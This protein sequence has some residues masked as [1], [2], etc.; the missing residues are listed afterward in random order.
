VK[1]STFTIRGPG[2][3]KKGR[4]S[5]GKGS[6]RRRRKLSVT[7]SLGA[8]EPRDPDELPRA[9]LERADEALYRAK[10]KGRNRVEA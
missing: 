10:E 6:T 7:V 5:R 3:R 1:G 2:R 4:K 9:V 8:A